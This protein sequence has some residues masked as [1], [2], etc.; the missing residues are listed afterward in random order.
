LARSGHGSFNRHFVGAW[1]ENAAGR[2]VRILA[3]WAKRDEF[4]Y[5][6]ELDDFWRNAWILAG[7]GT[8]TRR[9][10]GI[11]RATRRL[12]TYSLVWDGKNDAGRPLPQGLYSLHL[13]INREDGPPKEREIH[14]HSSI[15]IFC[16]DMAA[17]NAV[18]DKPE[19]R[20]V[21][22]TYGPGGK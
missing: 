22:A 15:D 2:R 16:G 14:T 10:R 18:A 9:L 19:L 20:G 3:L 5:V 1:V 6:R 8:S 13:D 17:A 12:G 7:E 11:S 21:K 4:G